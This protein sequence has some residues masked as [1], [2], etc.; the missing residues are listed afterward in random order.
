MRGGICY[1][2]LTLTVLFMNYHLPNPPLQIT[3]RQHIF[4]RSGLLRFSE[5][6]RLQTLNVVTGKI[7]WLTPYAAPFVVTRGWD[8]RSE[9]AIMSPIERSFGI[10]AKR[11]LGGGAITLD[12]AAHSV[13]SDMYSLWRIRLHRAKNPLPPLPLGMRMERSV[14]EDAMDQGEHYGII[15]PTFDGKIPG[16]MIAGP[17]LQLAL[18]RQAKIMSGKRWGIVRSKEGEFVL[19]DCFGDFMV[20]PLSPNCCLIADNDD[21]TVGIEVVSKLNA[22]AKAN[23]TTYLVARD[24]SVCPG[25]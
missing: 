25:I 23:S 6:G 22:V 14:S 1:R 8:Q 17:L 19:P 13:I 7:Q 4:P 11:I 20:M 12:I 24:F 16:R 21:V 5:R 3:K 15:T 10:I 18:D 2:R 9:S